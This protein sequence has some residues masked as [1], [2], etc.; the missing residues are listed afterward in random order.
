MKAAGFDS[1]NQ[2]DNSQEGSDAGLELGWAVTH[3]PASCRRTT[4]Y[5][6]LQHLNINTLGIQWNRTPKNYENIPA[7]D[8][9]MEVIKPDGTAV[10]YSPSSGG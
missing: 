5:H 9:A 10:N 2:I 8:A 1:E 3:A 6:T 7:V 4:I